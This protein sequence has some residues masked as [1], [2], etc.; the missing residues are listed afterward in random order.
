MSRLTRYRTL[1]ALTK[2]VQSNLEKWSISLLT[3]LFLFVSLFVYRAYHVDAVEAFSGHGIF[4]RALIQAVGTSFVFYVFQFHIA[5]YLK[6]DRRWKPLVLNG[7]AT[8]AGLNLTFLFFNYFYNWT[9]LYWSSYVMFLYEYPLIVFIPILIGYLIGMIRRQNAID[10]TLS[11]AINSATNLEFGSENGKQSI[12]LK[13]EYFLFLKSADNYIELYYRNGEGVKKQL[14][15]N[16]LKN[17]ERRYGQSP[18]VRRCHRS[19]LVNPSNVQ[20]TNMA[21]ANSNTLFIDQFEVPV[22]SKYLKD[23]QPYFQSYSLH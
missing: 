6:V 7:L 17:I 11:P 2:H 13:P 21:G 19:Y 8:F 1:K 22:S 12:A 23:F 14:F 5:S 9:E 10:T 16:T 15:R 20:V 4:S 18:Y 3:G